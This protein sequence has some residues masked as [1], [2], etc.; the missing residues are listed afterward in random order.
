MFIC[1]TAY[2]GGVRQYQK[3]Y[4]NNS[5]TL[6]NALDTFAEQFPEYSDC[7]IVAEEAPVIAAEEAHKWVEAVYAPANDTTFI[8]EYQRNA[9]GLIF[10]EQVVGFYHGEPDPELTEAYRHLGVVAEF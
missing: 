2:R 10:R 3:V 4:D 6:Q 7:V 5:Q 9:E 1:V 8:V